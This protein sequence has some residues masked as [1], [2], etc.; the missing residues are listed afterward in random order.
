MLTD[1]HVLGL[2]LLADVALTTAAA[3]YARPQWGD[4]DGDGRISRDELPK[5]SENIGNVSQDGAHYRKN[6][7]L[8]TTAQVLAEAFLFA[9]GYGDALSWPTL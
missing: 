4:K 2:A 5:L 9:M 8:L 7:S 6:F 3:L 1:F